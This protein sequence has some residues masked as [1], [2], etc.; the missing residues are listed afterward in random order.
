MRD[1]RAFDRR[2]RA[3]HDLS[4][5]LDNGLDMDQRQ[6]GGAGHSASGVRYDASYAAW[7]CSSGSVAATFHGSSSSMRLIRCSAIRSSTWRK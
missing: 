3:K 7:R 1:R 5:T 6:R 4:A 2:H